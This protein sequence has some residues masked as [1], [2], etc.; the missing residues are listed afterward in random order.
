MPSPAA[1]SIPA[2][3]VFAY[4][5]GLHNFREAL[6][7]LAMVLVP[8]FLMVS[9]IRFRGFKTLDLGWQRSYLT[10]FF[11]AMILAGIATHPRIALVLIAYTYLLSAFIGM[12]ISRVRRKPGTG[13]AEEPDADVH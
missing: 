3:T 4:P 1:A 10:L 6:P 2:T 11:V 5:E 7:A 12:A 13:P 9:T 8:A